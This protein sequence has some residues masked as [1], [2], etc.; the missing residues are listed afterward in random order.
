VSL[1]EPI[2]PDRNHIQQRDIRFWSKHWNVTRDDIR[3]AIEK[4]GNSA[5][6]VEKELALQ[7]SLK[8]AAY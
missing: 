5:T 7:N 8:E 2:K 1:S 3:L 6:A 4:V